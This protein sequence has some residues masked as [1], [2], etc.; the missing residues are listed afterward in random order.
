MP[1]TNR[2]VLLVDWLFTTPGILIQPLSGYA[3]AI[4]LGIPWILPGCS[5]PWGCLPFAVSL[6]NRESTPTLLAFDKLRPNQI[7]CDHFD[8]STYSVNLDMERKLP[9]LGSCRRLFVLK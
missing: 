6:S 9:G 3:L 8:A 1:V 7:I 5:P 2:H 4:F